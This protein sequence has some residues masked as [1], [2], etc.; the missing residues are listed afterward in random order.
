MLSRLKT[1]ETARSLIAGLAGF[2]VY[3]G[4]AWY[5][6]AAH[7]AEAGMRAGL[8]QGTYS[9]I[10]TF[11]TT[12]LMERVYAML[13][14]RNGAVALTTAMTSVLLFITAAGIHMIAAT[15]EILMTILPGWVIGTI[16]TAVYVIS[17]HRLATTTPPSP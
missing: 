9:L 15:P 3:G 11:S 12:L 6:N 10:L 7:S 2:L 4:W 14:T 17:L 13:K 8:L 16:Y 1:S 5:V